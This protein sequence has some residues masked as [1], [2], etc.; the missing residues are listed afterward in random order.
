[1]ECDC[2]VN[3][4]KL[5]FKEFTDEWKSDKISNLTTYVDY[6]GKTPT[7]TEKGIF[8]VTAKNVKKG[9]I[10]Y[11]CSKEYVEASQYNDIMYRGLPQVGDVLI[12]TEAPC[13]NVAQIDNVNVA[14]A[15]RI[16]KYRGKD[17]INN[18]FLKYELLSDYFQT[19]LKRVSSG[20]T[21]SGVKGSVL[22]Q[23]NIN[24]CS[25]N[26]QKKISKFLSLLDKKI[27]LQA[28]KIEVL[29]LFKKGLLDILINNMKIET[30]TTLNKIGT[31]YSGLTGKSK[32]AFETGNKKYIPF[33]SV[34]E[35][36]III[37]KLPNVLIKE[38]EHQNK[39]KSGD[40]FFTISSET[41]EEVGMCSTINCVEEDLYLNSFCFGYRL[42]NLS[43]IDNEFLCYLLLS[44]K[45]RNKISK[46]GQGF[47]RVNLSKNQLLNLNVE[48]P[49]IDFQIRIKNILNTLNILFDLEVSKLNTLNK[50]KKGLLQNMFV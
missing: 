3:V 18:T 5:R 31:Y 27:E 49:K 4:P 9:Y 8:L 38:K 15:Q 42:N 29:K 11:N 21:V 39:V 26:E 17:L 48:L 44:R 40:L 37:D 10:D 2:I 47:T 36:K 23:M 41:Q 33:M 24:Y 13:G 34:L 43:K 20:G 45:Y 7:K 16:I 6:R 28:K 1:M 12:T 22:H 35:N 30:T 32:E 25:K 50:Q 14:L 19:E 46:F